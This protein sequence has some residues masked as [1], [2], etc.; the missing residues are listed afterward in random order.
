MLLQQAAV[1][2]CGNVE[3]RS[4][5]SRARVA[6]MHKLNLAPGEQLTT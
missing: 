3:I 4:G 6:I 2:N 5:G 1:G